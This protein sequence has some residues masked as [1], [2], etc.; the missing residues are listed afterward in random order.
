MTLEHIHPF[1]TQALIATEDRNFYTH[2]GVDP[3]G[4]FRAIRDNAMAGEVVSGASTITMQLAR[5]HIGYSSRS[6]L[7]KLHELTLA[8]RLE[9][10]HS[11]DEILTAWLNS[12]YF[13]NQAYGIE[14][15]AQLYFGKPAVDLTDAEAAYLVGL[16]QNPAG[17]DPYRFPNSAH[18][19]FKRVLSSMVEAGTLSNSQVQTYLNIPLHITPRESVFR[20]PHFVEQIRNHY[21]DSL[22]TSPSIQTSLDAELQAEIEA[23]TR[24][25]LDRLDSEYVT[26]AAAIVIDNA[27]GEILAYMGSADYWNANIGGQN[28]GVLMLRQPGSALK[29]FTYAL[30]LESGAYTPATVLPDIEVQIPEAGGA[31]APKNYDKTY[32]GPVPFRE[33]LANSYNVPAVRLIRDLGVPQLLTR[34]QQA[35]YSSLNKTP[36]HYGVGLTLGNGEVQLLEMARAYAAFARQGYPLE[37]SFFSSVAPQSQAGTP[38]FSPEIAYLITDI[39]SDPE[40][41]EAAFGRYGPLELPFPTAVKTGTTKDYRDNWAVGYTPQYTVAVWVGNFD[42]TPMQKVSGVSGA[43]PLFKSIVLHL[44]E[45][46][47]FAEPDMLETMVICPLSGHQPS[48]SCPLRKKERFLTGTT[49]TDTCSVHQQ[50]LIDRRSN[51]LAAPGTPQEY[52]KPTLFTVLPDIYHPW[53]RQT[54]MAFPPTQYASVV[55]VKETE[56]ERLDTN[57]LQIAYPVS[58]MIFQLDP[59]LRSEYQQIKLEGLVPETIT[60]TSWWINDSLWTSNTASTRWPLKEG[61]HT[62]ELRENGS[63][64]GASV[65]IHVVK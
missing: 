18:V 30:A 40:A 62:I 14:A 45:S 2:I 26:N 43:G 6:L 49:P 63:T 53:M 25:H 44:G 12:A 31:F 21:G 3:K 48:S 52:I 20:A 1:A 33:A 42:G 17:H 7:R 19:R 64:R 29:P 10:H 56:R 51:L 57:G 38:I 39:L 11:K 46:G 55:E 5:M 37:L 28:D 35:G 54:N 27:T 24:G 9:V 65:Q 4:L 16:P 47:A 36:D 50:I 60:G 32:H 58:G 15:A 23:L 22:Y 8:I 61:V 59:I 41:R 34:L 13:G